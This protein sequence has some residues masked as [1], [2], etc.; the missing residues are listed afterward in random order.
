VTVPDSWVVLHHS[1][2]PSGSRTWGRRGGLLAPRPATTA[3]DLE[4]WFGAESHGKDDTPEAAEPSVVSW[5]ADLG[6]VQVT[7][8]PQQFWLLACSLGLL[9]VGLALY[10][11]GLPHK[12]LW[13]VLVLLGLGAATAGLLWP[14]VLAAVAYGCQP[15][16]VV[17]LAVLA[18]QWVVQHRYRRQLVFLPGFTRRKAGSS[19]VAVGNGKRGEPTTVDAPPSGSGQRPAGG[20]RS[21]S[22]RRQDGSASR[23]AAGGQ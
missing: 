14:G 13:P 11:L 7:W 15:G 9:A 16:L 8:V 21:D 23:A 18:T 19:L 10:F 17:L 2:E 20:S 1:G 3:A 6:A 22:G 12:V 4:R 5:E